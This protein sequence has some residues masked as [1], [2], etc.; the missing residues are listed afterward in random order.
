MR[1]FFLPYIIDPKTGED[2]KIE[3]VLEKDGQVLEGYLVSP[4]NRYPIV[5]GVPRFAGYQDDK[6]YTASFSD[7]WT[8]WPTTEFESK[9][10]G[11]PM[12]G[13]TMR[14][15]E[16]ITGMTGNIPGAIIADIGCGPGRFIEISRMKGASVIGIDMSDAV[17]PAADF[18]RTDQN[19]LICQADILQSPIKN[20]SVDGCFSFGVLH[21]SASPQGGFKEMVRV[22]KPGGWISVSVYGPGGVYDS[23][24]ITNYRR[25]FKAL[26]PLFGSYPPL[27]YS[28]AIA[29]IT[30]PIAKSRRLYQLLKPILGYFPHAALADLEWSVL[31][32]FDAVT[33]TNQVGISLYELFQWFKQAKLHDI[34]PGSWKGSNL[35][36]RK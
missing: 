22:T 12:E 7:E 26:W 1:T 10:K 21:H 16:R 25:L 23:F 2:L 18:F 3:I 5:R 31:T 17:D 4:S 33:P 27:M 19:V 13:H 9:N 14:M 30:Y 6:N 8:R 29:Y 24:I 11:K 28:Y 35:T 15:W 36:A 20:N 34:E 32:T